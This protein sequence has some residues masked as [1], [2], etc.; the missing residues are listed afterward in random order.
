M[1][2]ELTELE[3]L[4]VL[5]MLDTNEVKDNEMHA[6]LVY[7]L[8]K[9]QIDKLPRLPDAGELMVKLTELDA[10]VV[11]DKFLSV[12]EELRLVTIK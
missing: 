4:H 1:K 7:K 8:E 3:L 9:G 11:Y 6:K 12:A 2:I 5:A 10:L